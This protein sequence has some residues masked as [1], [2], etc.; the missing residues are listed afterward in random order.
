M[1]GDGII[2]RDP[3]IRHPVFTDNLLSTGSAMHT[4]YQL[5]LEFNFQNWILVCQ[6]DFVD[7]LFVVIAYFYPSIW[8][9]RVWKLNW[10]TACRVKHLLSPT[11]HGVW[12]SFWSSTQMHHW[13]LVTWHQPFRKVHN[14]SLKSS[15]NWRVE[16][17]CKVVPVD[18]FQ[19]VAT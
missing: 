18:L 16:S 5:N 19:P 3:H 9:S 13:W 8:S 10:P 12:A 4:H 7:S 14:S 6:H 1:S 2:T 17:C 11:G 15:G